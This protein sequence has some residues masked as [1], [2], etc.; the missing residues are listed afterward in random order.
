MANR[1]D[2]IGVVW[3]FN[4]TILDDV[5]IGLDAVNVLLERRS[6]PRIPDL[7]SYKEV[8]GFPMR[9]YYARVGFDFS[10]E[11]FDDVAP[12]W[13]REYLLREKG[14]P[15]CPTVPEALDALRDAGIPQYLVSASEET[16]LLGQVERLGIGKYFEEVHGLDNIYADSKE[17]LIRSFVARREGRTVFFGDTKHDAFCARSAGAEVILIA[18]GHQSERRLKLTNAPVVDRAIRAA[19]I[20]IGE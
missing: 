20:I 2:K 6:K 5:Q 13:L 3:D 19:K 7:A 11:S 16:M 18:A 8:F 4:G 12:E 14:A 9:E 17:A 1:Q 10:R 15:L